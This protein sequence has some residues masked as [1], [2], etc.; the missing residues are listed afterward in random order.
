MCWPKD[1]E[2]LLFSSRAKRGALE[3]RS[4][5]LLRLPGSV[6]PKPWPA[7]T[8]GRH[9]DWLSVNASSAAGVVHEAANTIFAAESS[10]DKSR[11]Q[12]LLCGLHAYTRQTLS[13]CCLTAHSLYNSVGTACV[14]RRPW[15]CI[16]MLC[17]PA[18]VRTPSARLCAPLRLDA[19]C[20]WDAVACTSTAEGRTPGGAKVWQRR[21][22]D[23]PSV[24]CRCYKLE[25]S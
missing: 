7:S 16:C 13:S 1:A 6:L 20:L 3:G 4:V 8:A 14:L 10:T 12:P 24:H 19:L 9:K 18:L 25:C 5:G 17:V 23:L 11:T 2:L 21:Q 22:C 15:V